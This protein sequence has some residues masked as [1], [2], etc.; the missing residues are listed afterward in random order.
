MLGHVNKLSGIP[1]SQVL[2]GGKELDSGRHSIPKIY[3]AMEPTAVF[4]PLKEMLLTEEAFQLAT[5][6]IFG[7]VQ[8][9]C[10][11]CLLLNYFA[12]LIGSK[13]LFFF[14][15]TSGLFYWCDYAYSYSCCI[16]MVPGQFSDQHW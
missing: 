6:E 14:S 7:P 11:L 10:S 2:F 9:T 3:G 4:V 15:R 16:G 8:V 13:L 5:T 12:H 1:G